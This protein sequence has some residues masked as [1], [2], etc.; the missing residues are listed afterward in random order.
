MI[1]NLILHNNYKNNL[2]KVPHE[3][4]RRQSGSCHRIDGFLV[5]ELQI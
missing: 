4:E 2:A 5:D 3:L 1:F